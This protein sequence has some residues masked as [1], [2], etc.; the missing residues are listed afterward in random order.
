M[1]VIRQ[2]INIYFKAA[3]LDSVFDR[4]LAGISSY[5]VPTAASKTTLQTGKVSLHGKEVTVSKQEQ[6]FVIKCSETLV[7]LAWV[8][9]NLIIA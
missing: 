5:K 4:L 8:F 6:D 1:F 3:L 9:C 2:Y 7:R